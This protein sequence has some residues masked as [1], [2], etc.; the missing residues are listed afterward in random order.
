MNRHFLLPIIAMFFFN[1]AFS[2]STPKPTDNYHLADTIEVT[3]SAENHFVPIFNYQKNS[4]G[5]IRVSFLIFDSPARLHSMRQ[6]NQNYLGAYTAVA[7]QLYK[8][9]NYLSVYLILLGL[10]F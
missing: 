9:L 3:K 10:L 1:V 4:R 7:D 2:L 8:S 5:N 6:F